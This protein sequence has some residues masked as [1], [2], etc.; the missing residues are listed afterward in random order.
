MSTKYKRMNINAKEG[1]ES[2]DWALS[3]TLSVKGGGNRY[4]I[5]ELCVKTCAG[6][7]LRLP[8]LI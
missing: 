8:P 4:G 6:L 5:S 3:R 7:G 2:R 1:T